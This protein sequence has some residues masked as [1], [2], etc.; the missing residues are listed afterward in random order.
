M[1]IVPFL[2][3]GQCL[4]SQTLGINIF[5]ADERCLAESMEGRLF[6][7]RLQYQ[8]QVPRTFSSTIDCFQK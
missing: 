2:T 3:S 6:A 4:P 8:C 1:K 7:L 5:Y